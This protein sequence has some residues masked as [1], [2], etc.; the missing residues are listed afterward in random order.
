MNNIIKDIQDVSS[1]FGF[2]FTQE[3]IIK[4]NKNKTNTVF[5]TYEEDNGFKINCVSK[6][7]D[8]IKLSTKP[9]LEELVN[10][11]DVESLSIFSKKGNSFYVPENT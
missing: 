6:V 3:K 11:T 1:F 7:H 10:M 4:R 2:N 8:M 5:F 9:S